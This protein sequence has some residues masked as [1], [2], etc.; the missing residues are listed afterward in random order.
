MSLHPDFKPAAW[1]GTTNTDGKVVGI[2]FD[3]ASGEICRL[4]LD[5][6][7]AR[8]LAE[9]ILFVLENYRRSGTNCHS[10]KSSGSP[11]LDGSP[12]EGQ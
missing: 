12:Q 7:S 9:S 4:V 5:L 10:D 11:N 1:R 3:I 8:N 6:A 2:S